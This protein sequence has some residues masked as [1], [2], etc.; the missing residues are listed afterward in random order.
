MSGNRW[1]RALQAEEQHVQEE[2]VWPWGTEGKL[3]LP[4]QQRRQDEVQETLT[5]KRADQMGF[6]GLRVT[7]PQSSKGP[8][9]RFKEGR[10]GI[11]AH[12]HFR[13]R[14]LAFLWEGDGGRLTEIQ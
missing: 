10:R 8:L 1:R 9:M 5:R 14:T 13:K 7:I 11:I 2:G 3:V 12:L 6:G 4:S